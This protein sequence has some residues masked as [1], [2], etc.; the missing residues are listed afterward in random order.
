M[1]GKYR[2]AVIGGRPAPVAGAKELGIDVVLVHEQG[3]YE[4]SVLRHCERVVHA[5]IADGQAILDVLK[6]LHEERPFDRVLTTTEPAGESTGFVVDALGLPGVTE[7]TAR[8][9]KD[10]VLTRK[11]LDRNGLSPVRYRQIESLADIKRFWAEVGD[12]IVVKPADGVASLHIHPV[13]WEDDA[14]RAWRA[15]R[16][17]GVESVIAEEYL[18]GPVVSVDS[19]SYGGRH[20]PIGY[21][22]YRMNDRYVEWEVST[23]SRVAAPHRAELFD[24]TRKLL[25]AVGLTEGPSHS[26]F[27]L[28]PKGPRVLESHARLAGSGAPELVRRAFGF[29][30]NRMFL[31]VPLGIDALPETSPEPLGGAAVRFFTPEPGTVTAVEAD[32]DA[33]DAI[34][35]VPKGEVPLVFLPY[36]DEFRDVEV[37]AVIAKHPG[38]VV[39]PLLTVADCVSGYV[40]ASGAD[41]ADAVAKC[42]RANDK[43]RFRTS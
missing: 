43:I 30:L 19:F 27:V 17:A 1:P 5:P 18:D 8:A 40:I 42:D 3:A 7:A 23:P 15:L 14:E 6:P 25:D 12:R 11:L 22:E 4:E 26:E 24:L 41:A 29:D 37:A 35:T 10:K 38:D 20:L 2:V 13:A 34:R 21:S 16:D 9:L 36:L 33:A 28:T 32:D 39:P 31:T